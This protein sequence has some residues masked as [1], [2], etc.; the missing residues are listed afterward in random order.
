MCLGMLLLLV[1]QK[2]GLAVIALSRLLCFSH[3][4]LLQGALWTNLSVICS[5][6][7]W[8]R[9]THGKTR[10]GKNIN[11]NLTLV[12]GTYTVRRNHHRYFQTWQWRDAPKGA[13]RL[14]WGWHCTPSAAHAGLMPRVVFFFFPVSGR[15]AELNKITKK[16]MVS[17]WICPLICQEQL[18]RRCSGAPGYKC[19]RAPP[20]SPQLPACTAGKESSSSYTSEMYINSFIYLISY[21]VSSEWSWMFAIVLKEWDLSLLWFCFWVLISKWW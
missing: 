11:A 16:P 6:L 20:W 12:W 3:V 9:L 10:P 1:I 2:A 19:G 13:L 18:Q 7:W 21:S 14:L 4:W 15:V 5:A 8:S 17:K